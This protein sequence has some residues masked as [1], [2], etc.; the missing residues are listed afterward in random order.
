VE[1]AG[2]ESRRPRQQ[3]GKSYIWSLPLLLGAAWLDGGAL[4][5]SICPRDVVYSSCQTWR[6]RD[7]ATLQLTIGN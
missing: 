1:Y 3:V 6:F 2:T 7:S 4:A 5:R